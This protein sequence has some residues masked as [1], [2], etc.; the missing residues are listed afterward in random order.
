MRPA[1]RAW[2]ISLK[3]LSGFLGGESVDVL[4][5]SKNG[6]EPL[7]EMQTSNYDCFSLSL[8]PRT[9]QKLCIRLGNKLV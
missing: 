9:L 1:A 7:P 2:S 8:S 4:R 6:F 5:R 3:L